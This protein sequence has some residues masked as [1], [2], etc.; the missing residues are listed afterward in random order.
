VTNGL[1]FY[2]VA[3]N[4]LWIEG[5]ARVF[6]NWQVKATVV[7]ASCRMLL[8][9]MTI[10]TVILSRMTLIGVTYSRM[11]LNK[12][13]ITTEILSRMTL[14]TFGR[15]ILSRITYSR[16]SLHQSDIDQNDIQQN[17]TQENDTL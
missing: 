3:W 10:T 2:T 7:V 8:Y 13:T 6:L 12:M 15:M 1:A 14:M 5:V 4:K 16:N 17:Y 9:K 11:L